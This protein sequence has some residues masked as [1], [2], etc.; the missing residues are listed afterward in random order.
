MNDNEFNYICSKIPN[1]LLPNSLRFIIN[2]DKLKCPLC[3][4][5]LYSIVDISMDGGYKMLLCE[6]KTH[7]YCQGFRSN[8]ILYQTD[9]LSNWLPD[10][11]TINKFELK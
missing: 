3:R 11:I 7:F 9:K 4:S 6:T 10:V 1:D 5:S 2:K 8:K